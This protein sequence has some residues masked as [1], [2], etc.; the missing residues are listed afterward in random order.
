VVS[1][2]WPLVSVWRLWTEPQVSHMDRIHC[3]VTLSISTPDVPV[4]TQ[5]SPHFRGLQ[6][7]ALP[8]FRYSWRFLISTSCA[9]RNVFTSLSDML[10][11][12]LPGTL[13][14]YVYIHGCRQDLVYSVMS[15]VYLFD[16]R[17]WWCVSVWPVNAWLAYYPNTV[18]DPTVYRASEVCPAERRWIIGLSGKIEGKIF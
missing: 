13:I 3:T 11:P 4:C 10:W 12:T 15:L 18:T 16:M 17:D 7:S 5:L 9:M 1:I 6:F 14:Y 8:Y 2:I